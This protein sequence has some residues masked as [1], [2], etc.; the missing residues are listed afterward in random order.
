MYFSEN[1]VII[2]AFLIHSYLISI[3]IK[4]EITQN[5]QHI[6]WLDLKHIYILFHTCY[7][8]CACGQNWVQGS[9]ERSDLLNISLFSFLFHQ[10]KILNISFTRVNWIDSMFTSSTKPSVVLSTWMFTWTWADDEET[11]GSVISPRRT[12]IPKR[13]SD[14]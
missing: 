9:A 6:I 13:S 2:R 1:T 12:H 8:S 4:T 5:G 14:S 3:A 11:L 10:V 7:N